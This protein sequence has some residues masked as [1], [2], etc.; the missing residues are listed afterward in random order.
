MA[1]K[2]CI[3]G[4]AYEIDGGKAM[5]DGTVYEIDHGVA[6]VDGT[7]YEVGFGPAMATVTLTTRLASSGESKQASLTLT[8]PEP[9]PHPILGV[10]SFESITLQAEAGLNGEVFEVPIGTL[11][12]CSVKSS[13]GSTS[14]TLNGTE[15]GSGYTHEITKN[16]SF[17]LR[18]KSDGGKGAGSITITET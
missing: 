7:A 11:A 6:N 9:I 12:K 18:V 14:V 8:F 2:V 16:V 4:T 3:G 1:H 5:V 10:G 15:V 13:Y 17:Y